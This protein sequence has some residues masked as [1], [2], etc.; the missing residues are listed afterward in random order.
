MCPTKSRPAEILRVSWNFENIEMF[1]VIQ[2]YKKEKEF[3][4]NVVGK[5]LNSKQALLVYSFEVFLS[6]GL[7]IGCFRYR[8]KDGAESVLLHKNSNKSSNILLHKR[9]LLVAIENNR[10]GG[11]I[12]V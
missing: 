7:P 2:D 8:P 5:R 9:H 12:A 6:Q 1:R 4:K 3:L 10:S 11:P